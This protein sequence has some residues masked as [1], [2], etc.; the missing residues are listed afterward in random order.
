MASEDSWSKDALEGMAALWE[1]SETIRKLFRDKKCLLVWPK[2]V[3]V[4]SMRLV[5][6]H[7]GKTKV[8]SYLIY[9]Q[10][11]VDTV[12]GQKLHHLGPDFFHQ[13]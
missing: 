5:C 12:D 8:Q 7:V 10:S 6:T 13:Q 2:Q 1:G 9:W 3:G 4:A 11:V